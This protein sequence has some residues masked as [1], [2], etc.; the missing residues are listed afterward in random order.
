MSILRCLIF[1]VKPY[2]YYGYNIHQN[3]NIAEGIHQ[4]LTER[5]LPKCQSN[6]NLHPDSLILGVVNGQVGLTGL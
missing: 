1:Y 2:R 6:R 3:A 5:E 4:Y